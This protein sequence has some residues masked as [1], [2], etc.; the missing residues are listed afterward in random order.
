MNSERNKGKE[1]EPKRHLWIQLMGLPASGKTTLGKHISE[2]FGMDFVGEIS[3]ENVSTFEEYYKPSSKDPSEVAFATQLIFLFDSRCKVLGFVKNEGI[4]YM[5]EKGPAVSEPSIYQNSIYAQA[6]LENF[7]N[8]MK[9]YNSFFEGMV[10]EEDHNPDLLVYFRLTYPTFEKRLRD[11]AITNPER[12]VELEEKTEY[13]QRLNQILEE[14]I[15]ENPLNLNIIIIDGDKYD[16]SNYKNKEDAVN[17]LLEE[18]TEEVKRRL[19]GNG[20]IVLPEAL[21]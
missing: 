15:T 5:L 1:T 7:P 18:L 8:K 2:R 3:V 10:E 13:W 17:E 16:F 14:W 9:K 19:G 12:A 20:A 6:R 11:R 21:I 4:K